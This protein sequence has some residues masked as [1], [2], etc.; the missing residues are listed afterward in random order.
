[1]VLQLFAQ[2]RNPV[3]KSIDHDPNLLSVMGKGSN[4]SGGAYVLSLVC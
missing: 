3:I 4:K 2:E 1:M